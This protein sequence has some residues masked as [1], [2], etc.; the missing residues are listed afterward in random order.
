MLY[1]SLLR[2]AVVG[3]EDNLDKLKEQKIAGNE[4]HRMDRM[5]TYKITI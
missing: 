5:G 4:I 2:F 1:Y 3:V